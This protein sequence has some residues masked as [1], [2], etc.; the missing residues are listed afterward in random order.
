M[1]IEILCLFVFIFWQVH[2]I[3]IST[4]SFCWPVSLDTYLSQ[5]LNKMWIQDFCQ[6]LQ[7]NVDLR[8]L[9]QGQLGEVLIL[10]HSNYDWNFL[11]KNFD[12]EKITNV[13]IKD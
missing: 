12:G 5:V 4:V 8:L 13:K 2:W 10:D 9:F 11:R 1:G 3:Q 6:V 7:K